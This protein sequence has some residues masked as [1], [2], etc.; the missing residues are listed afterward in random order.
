MTSFNGSDGSVKSKENFIVWAVEEEIKIKSFRAYPQQELDSF[1]F[2]GDSK[3][4]AIAMNHEVIY[5]NIST[6]E[7]FKNQLKADMDEL[8]ELN[9]LKCPHIQKITWL[10]DNQSIICVCY[11]TNYNP[12]NVP[13]TRIFIFNTVTKQERKWRAWG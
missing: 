4:L 6:I 1:Q 3:K 8:A 10:K 9:C 11:E 5:L 13:K 2:S 12:T 7:E